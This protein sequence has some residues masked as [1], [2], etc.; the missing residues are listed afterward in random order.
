MVILILPEE[1]ILYRHVREVACALTE[2][3]PLSEVSQEYVEFDATRAMSVL[4]YRSVK[5]QW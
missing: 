4:L 5:S 2:A 1:S 3:A